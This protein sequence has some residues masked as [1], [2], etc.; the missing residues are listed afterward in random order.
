[1]AKPPAAVASV[2]VNAPEPPVRAGLFADG[3]QSNALS[4]VGCV[5]G[6]AVKRLA[7]VAVEASILLAL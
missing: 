6:N 5:V 3:V 4:E 7:V 1:V 2:P